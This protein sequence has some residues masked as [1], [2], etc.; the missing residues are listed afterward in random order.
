MV[1]TASN[2][3]KADKRHLNGRVSEILSRG[4]VGSADIVGL[5]RRVV[6][7]RNGVT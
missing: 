3:T 2:L 7:Q 1:L 6:A 4:S 5:L